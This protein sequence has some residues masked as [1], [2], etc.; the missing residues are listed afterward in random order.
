MSQKNTDKKPYVKVARCIIN[1]ATTKEVVLSLNDGGEAQLWTTMNWEKYLEFITRNP[2]VRGTT[3]YPWTFIEFVDKPAIDLSK[4]ALLPEI[5]NGSEF[6][7]NIN[8][9]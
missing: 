1:P 2:Q 8:A 4:V 5:T 9:K 6:I 7:I 3:H